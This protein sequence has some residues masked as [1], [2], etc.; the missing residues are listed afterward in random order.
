MDPKLKV[1]ENS[2][3]HYKLNWNKWNEVKM[4]VN[5]FQFMMAPS[6]YITYIDI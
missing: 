2:T 4:K 1:N 3:V 6:G 5:S